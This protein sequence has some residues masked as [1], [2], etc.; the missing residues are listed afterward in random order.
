ML[1]A[2]ATPAA[3]SA[4]RA[5]SQ[6][7][8]APSK[9]LAVG[10]P[11]QRGQGVDGR[12]CHRLPPQA[13]LN[14]RTH[15]RL[16]PGTIQ[17]QGQRS[18]SSLIYRRR[19]Q[20]REVMSDV[21]YFARGQ[22]GC[23]VVGYADPGPIFAYRF[24]KR[25]M[26][27]Q[28]VLQRHGQAVRREQIACPLCRAR[29]LIALDQHQRHVGAGDFRRVRVDGHVRSP[30]PAIRLDDVDAAG[31]NRRDPFRPRAKHAHVGLRGQACG[32]DATQGA[33]PDHCDAHVCLN[34]RSTGHAGRL[35]GSRAG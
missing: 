1:L 20:V 5:S 21:V 26:V 34:A 33:G 7:R 35:I 4:S 13:R 27:V 11:P 28:P 32:I 22:H 17:E 6:R 8:S 23:A 31:A 16:Q 29:R 24:D 3:S 18:D 9:Q 30:Q 14:I 19:S 2:R 12:V 15:L 25:G 10:H